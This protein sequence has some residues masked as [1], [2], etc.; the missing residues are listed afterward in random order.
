MLVAL[1]LELRTSR[2]CG[3]AF[4]RI[5]KNTAAALGERPLDGML[6]AP[7]VRSG[8][9]ILLGIQNDRE[10]GP[11]V[12][13]GSGGVALELYQDI[14]FGAPPIDRATAEDM[15]NSTRVG[16]LIDGYRGQAAMDKNAVIDAL[17]AIGRVAS[18]LSDYVH[19]VDV[20]P[21]R[22]FEDGEGG[23]VLDSLVVLKGVEP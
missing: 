15:I 7:Y 4:E 20:N 1:L 17:M 22:V 6:V 16:R 8:T 9:D 3:A 14:A 18:D 19:S 23:V 11:V 2:P 13:F 5:E 10:F 21:Y 12:V